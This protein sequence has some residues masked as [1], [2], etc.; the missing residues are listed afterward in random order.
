M[1]KE[2]E[3]FVG[4]QLI[5]ENKDGIRYK[6]IV[7]RAYDNSFRFTAEGEHTEVMALLDDEGK[8]MALGKFYEYTIL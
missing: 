5:F 7:T 8:W 2:F 1:K 6:V 4:K 3:V